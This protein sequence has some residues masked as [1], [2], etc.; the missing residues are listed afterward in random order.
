[1]KGLSRLLRLRDHLV[2]LLVRPRCHLA[3]EVVE[4][5]LPRRAA[6]GEG[7]LLRFF[8]RH[9]AAS[10]SL[11]ARWV[12]SWSR[13]C[14]FQRFPSPHVVDH[15]R[16]TSSASS[17]ARFAHPAPPSTPRC[18][19]SPRRG[20]RPVPSSCIPGST[21]RGWDVRCHPDCR[22]TSR[23]ARTG[24]VRPGQIHRYLCSGETRK[25]PGIRPPRPVEGAAARGL[26]CDS[27]ATTDTVLGLFPVGIAWDHRWP[28]QS[29]SRPALL[30][31]LRGRIA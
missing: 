6:P 26:L 19:R 21:S 22:S 7:P 9:A 11:S 2:A 23:A 1:M 15:S 16:P 5:L 24:D 12:A 18:P 10:R 28:P 3:F 30:P 14:W 31:G 17:Q 27:A 25:P 13:I 8:A 20:A 4:R 29:A